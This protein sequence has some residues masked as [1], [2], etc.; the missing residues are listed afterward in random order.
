MLT[1]IINECN[2]VMHSGDE[3]K[4]STKVLSVRRKVVPLQA[5]Y[6]QKFIKD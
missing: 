1:F 2:G 4:N 6:Y 5:D 3:I